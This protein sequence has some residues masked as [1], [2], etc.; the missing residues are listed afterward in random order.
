MNIISEQEI[1]ASILKIIARHT[2]LTLGEIRHKT[3]AMRRKRRIPDESVFGLLE[4]F[5]DAGF[6][7]RLAVSGRVVYANNLAE[8]LH[9]AKAKDAD[10]SLAR[11]VTGLPTGIVNQTLENAIAFQKASDAKKRL[12]ELAMSSYTGPPKHAETEEERK[13]N[14]KVRRKKHALELEEAMN[15]DPLEGLDEPE[16]NFGV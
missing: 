15:K 4:K 11:V 14:E 10:I 6:I 8:T 7:K 13:A 5:V 2:R 1:L 3:R 9:Y 12:D 16:T